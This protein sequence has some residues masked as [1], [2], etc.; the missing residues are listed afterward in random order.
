MIGIDAALPA[1]SPEIKAA[2]ERESVPILDLAQVFAGAEG[3]LAQ[4]A[5]DVRYIQR[6][7]GFY[8]VTNHGVSQ[9]LIDR[10]FAQLERFFALPMERKLAM[11]VN[12]HQIGYIPPH[13]SIMKT[14]LTD[15]NTLPDTNEG[16]SLMRER[17]PDDPKVVADVRF[18]G[19]NQWPDDLPDFRKT[20]LAY[21]EAMERLGQK[22]LPIYAVALGKPPGFF[23]ACFQDAHF[24][25]R[26]SHY[27]A[28]AAAQGQYSI[29]AHTDH[30][31]MALL[32]MSAV[33][34][35]E[36]ERPSGGWLEAPIVPGA[37]VVNTGEFLNRWSN[38]VFRATPHRVIIPVRD[39]YA[40]TFHY[41]PA[42]DTVAAP[43][44]TCVGPDNPPRYEPKTFIQHM[45][46]YIDASYKPLRDAANS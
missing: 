39:R 25:N 3:A 18:S 37:I 13:A 2:V 4:A 44:D 29:G 28:S 9:A 26:N 34:A 46:D 36:V 43:L 10:A 31:F 20:F 27:P 8:Y 41:S 35:L 19:L 24:Y 23:D 30:N 45:T 15:A 38:G 14:A 33:P 12:R 32:P 21:H 16:L 22:L 1:P 17:S 7:L 6:N 5:A 11:R 42:D 40:L